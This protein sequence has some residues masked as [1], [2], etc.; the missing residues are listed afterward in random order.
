MNRLF[1]HIFASAVAAFLLISAS[2]T[3]RAQ[4]RM[5]FPGDD[6]TPSA[7]ALP[8]IVEK[9]DAQLPLDLAFTRSDGTPVK[10]RDCFNHGRPVVLSLVYFSCPNLCGFTQTSLV[11][12]V[13]E[14]PH[15]IQLG[16]DYDILV[17][18]IDADDTPKDAAAKRKKYL[19][20]VPLPENQ[21]GFTYLT[22][23]GANIRALADA[24][25]Y[26]FR[27][28]P[29]GKGAVKIAHDTGIFV[30]TPGGRLSQTILG[31]SYEP[32]LLHYRLLEASNGKI[33]SG[34]LNFALACGACYFDPKTG[35]YTQNP[36]FYAGTATGIL[37]VFGVIGM[38]I[39]LFHGDSKRRRLAGDTPVDDSP[40]A[41]P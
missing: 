37:S 30:C 21:T 3:A 24:V 6:G 19:S 41:T 29:P 12:F 14:A 17:V 2:G 31:I 35:H 36:W 38:L 39:M 7:E 4:Y 40:P 28:N 15:G 1:Q 33:G 20:L 9:T 5:D 25:G 22:G 16:K 18:S 23:S 32:D 11:E 10:L 34:L 27:I 13:R 8:P 26:P